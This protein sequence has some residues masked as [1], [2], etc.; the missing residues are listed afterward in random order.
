MTP[1][2][3]VSILAVLLGVVVTFYIVN[4]LHTPSHDP[5]LRL[6]GYTLF[7]QPSRSMEP[8]IRE[9]AVFFVSAWEYRTSDPQV[10][11]IVVFQ[12]PPDPSVFYVKRVIATGG[13]TVEIRDG[14]VILD[15][16][17]LAE[18]YLEGE[19]LQSDLAK[20]MAPIRVPSGSYFVLGD[21][22]DNSADSRVWGFVPRS[23]I[24]GR[25]IH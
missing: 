21:N 22:R 25:A 24:V 8:T 23:N 1:R 18:P 9:N 2:R 7:R 19:T 3:L 11:D 16:H 12:Y 13:S 14:A 10:G 15:G 6:W 17:K 5:R 4:P 20:T